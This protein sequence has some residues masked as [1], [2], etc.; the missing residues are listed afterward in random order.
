VIGAVTATSDPAD[1]LTRQLERFG[2]AVRGRFVPAS[3]T[4]DREV[5]PVSAYLDRAHLETQMPRTIPESDVAGVDRRVIGSRFVREHSLGVVPPVLV[6]LAMGIGLD[7][8]AARARSV[9]H[10]WH[11]RGSSAF[12]PHSLS[13]G[14]DSFALCAECHPSPRAMVP[15]VPTHEALRAQVWRQLF[16]EHLAPLFDTVLGMVKVSPRVLWASAAEAA[17]RVA[18]LAAE[19]LSAQEARPFIDEVDA[20]LAA[21]RLPGLSGPNP[22]RGLLDWKDIGRSDF[23]HGLMLRSVCC[24]C[25]T[26]PDRRGQVY[27]GACP[28]PSVETLIAV[29]GRP[30]SDPRTTT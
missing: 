9:W 24:M 25:F 12:A 29:Q 15:M 3:A 2:P 27:C 19:Q 7:A 23:P 13:V 10:N 8:S 26:L 28:L 17:G 14:T 5:Q 1:L 18:T 30:A 22:L 21:E 4:G 11:L 16:A 6:G 20:I